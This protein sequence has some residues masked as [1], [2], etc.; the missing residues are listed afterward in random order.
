MNDQNSYY[1]MA[2]TKPVYAGFFRRW[3]AH[4]IDTA[5]GFILLVVL[6]PLMGPMTF[7]RADSGAFDGL[8]WFLLFL[9][10]LYGAL[11]ESSRLQGTL[12][13]LIM[14]IQVANVEGERLSFLNALGRSALKIIS[15]LFMG[16]GCLIAAFTDKRQ[17][18]HDFPAHSIV[19]RRNAARAS[20][21]TAAPYMPAAPQ[22]P[23]APPAA[24][25]PNPAP[26][27]QTPA[28]QAMTG[29]AN[30]L[31]GWETKGTVVQNILPDE[32]PAIKAEFQRVL[33]SQLAAAGLPMSNVGS[34]NRIHILGH[35]ILLDGGKRAQRY[36]T[37]GLAG[38]ARLEAE[39][40]VIVNGVRLTTLYAKGE[41]G[42]AFQVFG[43]ENKRM[44]KI[45]AG[46]CAG[47]I[48]RQA[49]QALASLRKEMPA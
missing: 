28:P 18:L 39:G 31:C 25:G 44:L 12:G 19:V 3:L 43:G 35:F 40:A 16:M 9:W 17:A 2:G 32:L 27:R 49:I 21:S 47:Q 26:V 10:V 34:A 45:S 6:M 23:S 1:G 7:E 42:F 41:T 20:Y 22:A 48:A 15:M 4:T 46:N 13:K 29:P 11:M 5:I 37:N 36:F 14:G 33:Y 38:K 24:P 30:V 8:L